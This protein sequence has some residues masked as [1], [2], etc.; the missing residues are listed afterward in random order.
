[1]KKRITSC[2]IAIALAI[3]M[4]STNAFVVDTKA[5]SRADVIEN[6]VDG[7]KKDV[8]KFH[9]T[10]IRDKSGSRIVINEDYKEP[11][12]TKKRGF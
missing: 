1:M 11:K 3:S 12:R 5:V 2:V 7:L 10:H 8:E 6:V 4:I 9:R